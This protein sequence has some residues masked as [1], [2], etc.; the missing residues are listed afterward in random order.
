MGSDKGLLK[1]GNH[2]WAQIVASNIISLQIP[3]LIS[4]NKTQI[5]LYSQIFSADQLVMDKEGLPVKGPLLGLLSTHQQFPGEDLLVL[6]CDMINM[7]DD[8]LQNLLATYKEEAFQAYVFTTNGKIQPLCGVYTSKGLKHILDLCIKN[9]LQ[10]FSMMYALECLNTKYIS[11]NNF[12]EYFANYN[13]VEEISTIK[14][15]G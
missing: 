15:I 1:Q 8:V 13:S 3:T 2:V 5:D 7:Q 14:S 12:T 9:Q 4:V 6:A 10:K 11:A